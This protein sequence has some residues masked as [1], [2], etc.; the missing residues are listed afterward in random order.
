MEFLHVVRGCQNH[1]PWFN[2][3][4][5]DLVFAVPG[6]KYSL[7]FLY[8]SCSNYVLLVRDETTPLIRWAKQIN[9]NETETSL[10][11]MV[12]PCWRLPTLPTPLVAQESLG[13]H[14]ARLDLSDPLL[15]Q[16]PQVVARHTQAWSLWRAAP[17]VLTCMST[18]SNIAQTL[19][20]KRPKIIESHPMSKSIFVKGRCQSHRWATTW[21]CGCYQRTD[22]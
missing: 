5:N 20:W 15:A 9:N 1:I 8:T 14:L 12:R 16:E 2:I 11:A 17:M 18:F 4:I 19:Q 22:L 6:C 3:N 7:P 21:G 13:Q 10:Q